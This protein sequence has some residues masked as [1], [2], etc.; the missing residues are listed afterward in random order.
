MFGNFDICEFVS[1]KI[2][3]LQEKRFR[4]V[5]SR[6]FRKSNGSWRRNAIVDLVSIYL[7]MERLS[8]DVFRSILETVSKRLQG[9]ARQR[10]AHGAGV[11]LAVGH[12]RVRHERHHPHQNL[13]QRTALSLG[14]TQPNSRKIVS[15]RQ[16]CSE[17]PSDAVQRKVAG[18]RSV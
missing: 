11:H 4:I 9:W 10:V 2:E 13:R 8:T 5:Q 12:E 7:Q 14:E 17:Y 6:F 3:N 18:K 16:P 1:V 15:K